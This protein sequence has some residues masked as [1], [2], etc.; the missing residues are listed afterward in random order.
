MNI[1]R[2]KFNFTMVTNPNT[3]TKIVKQ[4]KKEGRLEFFLNTRNS[5]T[6]KREYWIFYYSLK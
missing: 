4:L 2:T 5:T 6:Y 3:A 1:N